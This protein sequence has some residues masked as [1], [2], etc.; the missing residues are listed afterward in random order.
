ML[1]AFRLRRVGITSY[2]AA[3]YAA[4]LFHAAGDWDWQLAGVTL[5]VIFI[6]V[7]LLV[8]AEPD[9]TPTSGAA[10]HALALAGS[11]VILACLMTLGD[12]PL[13]R[14]TAAADAGNW[15]ISA[16]EARHAERWMPWSSE[17]W[18]I[19]GEAELALGEKAQARRALL[20]A[21]SKDPQSWQ[22]WFDLSAADRGAASARALARA[23]RLNPLSPEIAQIQQTSPVSH[24]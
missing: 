11:A 7:A 19:L 13:T 12:V 22:I 10:R 24:V 21:R 2:A 1:A 17:P 14:A 18:R 23:R 4:F 9:S 16:R 8:A 6:G 20:V 3:A 15:R 5:P